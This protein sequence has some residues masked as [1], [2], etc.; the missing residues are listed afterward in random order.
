MAFFYALLGAAVGSFL[1]LCID[2]L[3]HGRSILVPR[4]HCDACGHPL[5]VRDLVPV[6]SYLMLRGLCRYCGARI[7]LRI[8]MVEVA[9]AASFG[10]LWWQLGPSL[11]TLI[12]SFYASLFILIFAI[13]LEHRLVLNSVIYPALVVA[14]FI[15]LLSGLA[16]LE[17]LAGGTVGFALLLLPALAYRGGMGGGDIKL[18]SFIGLILGFPQILIAI[19]VAALSGG[20][21]AAWLLLTG[22]RGRKDPIP[23]APFLVL[24]ATVSLIWGPNLSRWYLGLYR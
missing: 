15:A 5:A 17:I 21:V 11:S 18:A 7:P 14:P 20:L 2:R 4:S 22:L 24:G 1:N 12:L 8:L 9:A 3:P 16:P 19:L 6:F 10:L 23:F 13:D